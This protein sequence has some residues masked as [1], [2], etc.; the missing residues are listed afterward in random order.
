MIASRVFV[1][2][3]TVTAVLLWHDELPKMIRLARLAVN[4]KAKLAGGRPVY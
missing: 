1:F 4:A 2:S 3:L